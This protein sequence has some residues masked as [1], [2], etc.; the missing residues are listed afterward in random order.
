M[1][2]YQHRLAKNNIS[3]QDIDKLEHYIC[4]AVKSLCENH[5]Y[6][7]IVPNK[8]Q[9]F[10][11]EQS[12]EFLFD[13]HE[14]AGEINK[15]FSNMIKDFEKNAGSTPENMIKLLLGR[16]MANNIEIDDLRKDVEN[17]SNLILSEHYSS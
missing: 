1:Y 12:Y 8:L 15:A 7:P 17:L 3:I 11:I 14:C 6:E 4:L 9:D 10:M 5:N 2:E 16:S 13:I